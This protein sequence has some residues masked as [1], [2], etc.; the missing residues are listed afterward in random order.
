VTV[1]GL[2]IF[3]HHAELLAGSAISP[4]VARERGYASVDTKARLEQ[5]GFSK[6]QRNVPGLLIPV[7][8]VDGEI[9]GHE[10]RPDLPRV[11]E[12]G[13]VRK[14]EKPFGAV[15]RLDVHPR[16]LPVLDDPTVPL[17]ITEGA[18]K[19]DAAV[20][21]DLTCVGIAG[22]YGWRGTVP[23]T[24]GKVV[25]P[26]WQHVALN[27]RDVV[28]CFDADA[29][30]KGS[31]RK[32][33]DALAQW[34]RTVKDATV[35]YCVLPDLGDGNTG[36]DDYLAAG[37]PVD[38]LRQLVFLALPDIAGTLRL[39]STNG[40]SVSAMSA[41]AGSATLD[42][43]IRT[44]SERLELSDADPLYA[45]LGTV[46]ALHLPGDPVWLLNVDGSSGGKTELI[47]PLAALPEVHLCAT[48]TEAA[49]LSGTSR[50]ERAANATGGVLRQVG[51]RG[52]ILLKDFTS[53]LSMQRDTRSQTLAALREIYDGRWNRP[54][55]TDGGQILEWAGKCAL[56]A[57]CTEAWDA[58]HEVVSMMGDRFLIV[59]N[60]HASRSRFGRRALRLAGDEAE[61]RQTL[62]AAVR[63]LFA[64]GLR[65]PLPIPDD[66]LLIDVA[67]L[68]T[69]AR[70]PVLRDGHREMIMPLAPEMPGRFIKAL[71]GLWRGLTALG[72][73]PA[74]AWRVVMRVAF[75]SMPRV[76]HTVLAA[77]PE[78]GDWRDTG[79]VREESR[80][81]ASTARRALEEL[82]A[83]GVIE[84]Q[85]STG[86]NKGAGWRLTDEY[87]AT[88]RRRHQPLSDIADTRDGA[89]LGA[90]AVERDEPRAPTPDHG[91][92]T[93]ESRENHPDA[94]T[95]EEP[96]GTLNHAGALELL[97][98]TFPS[99][100]IV[101][102]EPAP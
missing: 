79:H 68:V 52:A 54:V 18:R 97:T 22:V 94:G 78:S 76:R 11:T 81:P 37:H 6:T 8:G 85:A 7:H 60:R 19:V 27:G 84:H 32:A 36:L 96:V 59:R 91:D 42:D 21:A 63:D 13:K 57:G 48:L 10:Y 3:D 5:L 16:V 24:K 31:V 102:Q 29:M 71:A 95:G 100:E 26:D 45:V 38:E 83:H 15:N 34:L 70:S 66:E 39:T 67:D 25:L 51:A 75:D 73:D 46:A 77:L 50:K 92:R 12:A 30:T 56:V 1:Y 64:S 9:V 72:A 53:V 89:D 87:R 55:G 58:A 98:A 2:A 17:W 20:S 47:A 23:E 82:H 62:A 14:Y 69:L 90:T 93:G 40:S 65:D 33:L 99:A 43:V 80:L 44:F 35:R 88:W 28:L 41:G 49:L 86:G 61:T 101:G 4:D 74:T